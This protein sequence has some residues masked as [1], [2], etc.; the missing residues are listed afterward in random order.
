[1]DYLLLLLLLGCMENGS[2]ESSLSSSLITW[3]TTAFLALP[4]VD[5]CVELGCVVLVFCTDDDKGLLNSSS[6]S[7][8]TSSTTLPLGLL[9]L[10]AELNANK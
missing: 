4:L 6:S 9:L 7:E 3:V 10:D 5:T 2:S 1:M 8:I